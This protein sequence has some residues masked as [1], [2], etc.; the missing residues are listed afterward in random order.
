MLTTDEL[1]IQPIACG[2]PIVIGLV[3][4]MPD[5]ALRT[6]ERQ[7]HDLLSAASSNRMIHLSHFSLPGLP[8]AEAAQSHID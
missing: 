5:A 8:R 2:E 6:T 1:P 7:F 3:N 4:N